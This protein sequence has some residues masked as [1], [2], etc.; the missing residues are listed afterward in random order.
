MNKNQKPCP[1]CGRSM[2]RQSKKCRDCHRKILQSTEYRA[3][4]SEQR[5][6]QPSYER[7]QKH[8]A[9][10][11]KVCKNSAA[12]KAH[13][14]ARRGVPIPPETIARRKAWWTP[15]RR[16]AARQRGLLMAENREWLVRIA[17]ALS[18]EN[19]P[20][21]QGKGQET[22]YAPG[23]GRMYR[24]KLRARS[25]GACELCGVT[26]KHLDLHHRDFAKSNHSPDNIMV[27]CR[28]C[29]KTLHFA[30]SSST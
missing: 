12:R 29:H 9:T 8:R 17:E 2:H 1:L 7:T 19:N 3:K 5:R 14:K 22:G 24:S 26:G 11:S 25:E 18:G 10:M 27:L 6:G 23:W 4:M 15:K 30:N 20:N 21:Y 16:E 13:T 28:S